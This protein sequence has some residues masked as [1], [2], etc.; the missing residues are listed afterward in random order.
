MMLSE[1]T[2]K[3]FGFTCWLG[4]VF[5]FELLKFSKLIW[6]FWDVDC[7]IG[8]AGRLVCIAELEWR[9]CWICCCCC[10]KEEDGDNDCC[11]G[12]RPVLVPGDEVTGETVSCFGNKCAED[13][14]IIE[15][16]CDGIILLTNCW[17]K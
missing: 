14:G 15:D 5:V 3:K 8:C 1:E 17:L 9:C 13:A 12:E 7:K 11:V 6:E 10:C 4:F 16:D 2:I